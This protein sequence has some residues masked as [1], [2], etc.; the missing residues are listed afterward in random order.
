VGSRTLPFLMKRPLRIGGTLIVLALALAYIL[1]KVDLRTTAQIIADAQPGWV[2]VS[3]L[4]IFAMIV[5][6]AWRWQLLLLVRGI[7]ES[8]PWLV[9]TYFVSYAVAQLMPTSVGGDASRI[10]ETVRRH[11]G[12]ASPIA[13]SVL[14]ERAIGGA[15]TLLLAAVGFLLAIGRYSVGAFVWLELMLV[16]V[17]IVFAVVFFSRAARSRLVL[18]VPLARKLHVERLARAIYHGIHGYRDSP[19]TLGVV[20]TTTLFVQIAAILS[21]YAAAR[22]VGIDVSP[23]IYLVLGPL[24]FLVTLVP[25]TINGLGVREAF[26]VS[27]LGSLDVAPEPAFACGFLFFLMTVLPAV[28]GLG[29]MLREGLSRPPV[30]DVSR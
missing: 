13:G 27:F 1:R 8:L 10:Y 19:G 23:L 22:A 20:F 7:R 3:A 14:V 18:I 11:P 25:F 30:P 12:H 16:A 28:G 26:F 21:I 29:V 2:A 15:V 17:T 9:R 24:L 4:F 6:M 5:P